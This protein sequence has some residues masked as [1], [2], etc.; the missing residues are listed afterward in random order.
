MMHML[1]RL[2]R[3]IDTSEADAAIA[4]AHQSIRDVAVRARALRM[5]IACGDPSPAIRRLTLQVYE[6]ASHILRR[7]FPADAEPIP[8]EMR[9]LLD[10][11]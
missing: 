7:A 4:E 9:D 11:M 1:A 10:R 8:A 3:P 5:D 2:F 6:G